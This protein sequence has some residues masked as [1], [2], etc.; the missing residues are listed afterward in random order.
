MQILCLEGDLPGARLTGITHQNV[1]TSLHPLDRVGLSDTA[2]GQIGRDQTD[3]VD[4]I[5][6]IQLEG[7]APQIRT[8]GILHTVC[9]VISVYVLQ[10]TVHIVVGIGGTHAVL[11]VNQLGR[12]RRLPL[13]ILVETENIE[14]VHVGGGSHDVL[15]T[16]SRGGQGHSPYQSDSG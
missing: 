7:D 10:L 16:G 3:A 4:H 14:I 5:R 6:P 9:G 1:K 8:V 11:T 12:I 13:P 15:L 2:G